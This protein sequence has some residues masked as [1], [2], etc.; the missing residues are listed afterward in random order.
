MNSPVFKGRNSN[1]HESLHLH[2]YSLSVA[3]LCVR[4]GYTEDPASPLVFPSLT[5]IYTHLRNKSYVLHISRY[6]NHDDRCSRQFF[7]PFLTAAATPLKSRNCAHYG[8]V[9]RVSAFDWQLIFFSARQTYTAIFHYANMLPS[10]P[11]AVEISLFNIF[12]NIVFV[13][14]IFAGE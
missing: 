3:I 8:A 4:P 9:T 7:F 2:P 13:N 12:A 14:G 5:R 6:V 11:P 1:V 10:F